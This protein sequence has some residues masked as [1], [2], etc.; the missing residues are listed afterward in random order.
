VDAWLTLDAA[1]KIADMRGRVIRDAGRRGEIAIDHAGRSPRVTRA[2]IE[3]WIASRR[4]GRTVDG[5]AP[6]VQAATEALVA[7]PAA[8]AA[9]GGPSAPAASGGGSSLA[10][11]TFNFY[12]VEGAKDAED[13]FREM[14]AGLLTRAGGGVPA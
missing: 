1:G 5:G 9:S 8:P 14:I 13:R 6:G 12:G 2:E 4:R 3:R 10:G 11:A 7:P